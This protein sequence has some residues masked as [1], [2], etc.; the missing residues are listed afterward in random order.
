M[1]SVVIPTIT[2]R[3]HW[4]HNAMK[5]YPGC[6]LIVI[7]DQPTCGI[8][9]N[10]GI[11]E[12]SGS[13]ILLAADDI[14]PAVQEWAAAAI[15]WTGQGYLPCARI[16]NTD[17]TLQSCGYWVEEVGTGSICRFA[18]IPFAT[19]EQL[20]AIGPIIDTHYYT[21]VWFSDMGRR[22]GYETVVVRE[23]CFYHHFAPEGRVDDRLEPDRLLYEQALRRV[24]TSS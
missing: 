9:W 19:R 17:G 5:C 20:A 15:Y 3:E 6:E 7:K 14:A 16:L 11:Q 21:D 12:A 4:L 23:F 24:R 18:R 1:I 10:Q 2:G 8:A 22:H 13:H